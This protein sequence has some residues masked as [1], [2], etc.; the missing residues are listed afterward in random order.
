MTSVFQSSYGSRSRFK[1]PER[2][3][4]F[5]VSAREPKFGMPPWWPAM[6][7][8][9]YPTP[10]AQASFAPAVEWSTRTPPSNRR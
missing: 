4:S 6:A 7:S 10:C 2:V 5:L 8:A 3:A 1:R 9:R